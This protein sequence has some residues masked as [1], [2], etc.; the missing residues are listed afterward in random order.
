M[1]HFLGIS[2]IFVFHVQAQ[3]VFSA[4]DFAEIP[5]K[6]IAWF[7][8]LGI[9]LKQSLPVAITRVVAGGKLQFPGFKAAGGAGN[10]AYIDSFIGQR[11]TIFDI[12]EGQMGVR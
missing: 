6:Y 9:A 2:A 10:D 1:Y 4:F 5:R 3:A 8:H 11:V 12:F 7:S